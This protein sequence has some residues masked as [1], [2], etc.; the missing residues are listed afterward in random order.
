MPKLR[1]LMAGGEIAELTPG[2]PCVTYHV[3]VAMT[4][5][6]RPPPPASFPLD[7]VPPTMVY[8]RP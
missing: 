7:F 6:R 5:S 1:S 2:F 4:T 3:Q 8:I